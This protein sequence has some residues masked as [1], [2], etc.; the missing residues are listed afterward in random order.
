[1]LPVVVGVLFTLLH[2]LV[3]AYVLAMLTALIYGEVTEPHVKKQ[4]VRTR[5]N[6]TKSPTEVKI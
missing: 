5:K 4:R 2:A 6:K 1:M 3:Q